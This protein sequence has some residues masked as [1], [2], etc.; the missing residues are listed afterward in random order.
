MNTNVGTLDR[1]FRILLGAALIAY[2]IPVGFPATGWNW[3]GWIGFVP[4]LT[5]LVGWC[6]LYAVLGMSTCPRPLRR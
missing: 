5:A 2:A 3:V 4:I 1:V 6:P